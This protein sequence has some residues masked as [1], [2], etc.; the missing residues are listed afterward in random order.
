M[1]PEI[2][3]SWLPVALYPLKSDSAANYAG[4]PDYVP[5]GTPVPNAS[6]SNVVPK[7]IKDSSRPLYK[8][9]SAA[10]N[11]SSNAPA[12]YPL[13]SDSAAHYAGRPAYLPYKAPIPDSNNISDDGNVSKPLNAA[14]A[15][16][17][18]YASTAPAFLATLYP[19]RSGSVEALYPAA[20]PEETARRSER[21]ESP[22]V[23]SWQARLEAAA[24]SARSHWQKMLAAV[25]G[26]K[27][28][29]AS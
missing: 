21:S 10:L 27:T 29:G 4:R 8:A 24:S 11:Y 6:E 28:S 20:A 13:K 1:A 2:V 7:S 14:A 18:D 25:V 19:M 3:P 17:L 9:S 23:P 5:H 16:A 15:T 22:A 12:V 26:D